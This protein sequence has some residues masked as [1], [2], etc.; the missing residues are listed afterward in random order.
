MCNDLLVT[1][2]AILDRAGLDGAADRTKPRSLP[3]AAG[4]TEERSHYQQLSLT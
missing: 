1:S 2:L 4:Q 3:A